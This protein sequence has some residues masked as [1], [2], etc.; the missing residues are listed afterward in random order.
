MYLDRHL[1]P[2]SRFSRIEYD[3][4]YNKISI[5]KVTFLQYYHTCDIFDFGYTE[6]LS[7]HGSGTKYSTSPA[8]KEDP[9]FPL[10]VIPLGTRDL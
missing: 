9:H 1:I 3:S 7:T 6:Q 2:N 5:I 4:N 10:H 8:F